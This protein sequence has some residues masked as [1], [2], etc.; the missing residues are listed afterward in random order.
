LYYDVLAPHA[1]TI[2][3]W[4]TEYHQVMASAEAIIEWYKGTGL[5][6]YLDALSEKDKQE[7]LAEYLQH[8]RE[9]YPV[10]PDGRVLW[11]IRESR[12]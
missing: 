11:L 6:P 10:R 8:I 4:E 9:A 1:T 2:D 12:A 7:F 3:L 5:R